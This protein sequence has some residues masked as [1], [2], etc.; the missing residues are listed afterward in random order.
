MT[1]K[2]VVIP[3]ERQRIAAFLAQCGLKF[4]NNIDRTI[5]V[6]ENGGIIATVSASKYVIKCL[7]V[8]PEWRSENLAAT[9]VG[10]MI[11]RL[12][13]DGIFHYHIFT[14]PEYRRVFE[15]FGFS[16]ISEDGT[17]VAL[18]G[19]EGDISSTIEQMRVRM[20][21]SL[22]ITEINEN[23]DIGCVVLNGNPFTNGHLKLVEYA[24]EQ[25][26]YVLV[27]VLEEDESYFSFK[28]RYAMAYLALK[29]MSNVLVLPSSE[30]II[31]ASTFPGYF[32][33]T[34]D[35]TTAEY[36]KYD[37]NLF[38][39]YFMPK[40]G[41]RKRYV[42]SETSDYMKI[43]NTALKEALGDKL[44]ILPRYEENGKVI[45][46]KTVRELIEAGK[47]DEALELIPRNNYA[48]FLSLIKSRNV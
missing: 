44:E 19:G 41:V 48:V 36:A 25:H 42:G 38:K 8:A 20:K 5:Y 21:F 7:A 43:Y 1:V 9:V 29:P 23:T 34:V 3:A 45:S 16:V 2:E 31:S 37:A 14:K 10:E 22:G 28:E 27:F 39:N 47:T 18:E 6:E 46:A 15:S 17:V 4:E 40:L 33:K 30:Y 12:H 11:N 32:L 13:A 26:K 35:E 24:A